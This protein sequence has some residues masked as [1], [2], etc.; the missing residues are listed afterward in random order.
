MTLQ[1]LWG[2]TDDYATTFLLL[3][4][5]SAAVVALNCCHTNDILITSILMTRGRRY[6]S[7]M[8]SSNSSLATVEFHNDSVALHMTTWL[9]TELRARPFYCDCMRR[10]RLSTFQYTVSRKPR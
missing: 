6:W 4:M 8:V 1:Y 9:L 7:G 5:F 2:V 3:V 10:R